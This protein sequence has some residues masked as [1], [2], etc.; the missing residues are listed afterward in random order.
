MSGINDVRFSEGEPKNREQARNIGADCKAD[1][2]DLPTPS[3]PGARVKLTDY[4]IEL[5]EVMDG[6]RADVGMARYRV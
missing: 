5:L 3:A 2:T 4:E 6:R 1:S